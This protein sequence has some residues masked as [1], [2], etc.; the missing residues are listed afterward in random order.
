MH[1]KLP[2]SKQQGTQHFQEH[3]KDSGKALK[4]L[5]G[6]STLFFTNAHDTSVT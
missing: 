2:S 4:G 5:E 3:F 6:N 1:S